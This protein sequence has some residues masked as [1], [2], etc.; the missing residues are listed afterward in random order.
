[1]G[2]KGLAFAYYVKHNSV[3]RTFGVNWATALDQLSA[4]MQSPHRAVPGPVRP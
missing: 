1:M 2:A 4:V 3:N